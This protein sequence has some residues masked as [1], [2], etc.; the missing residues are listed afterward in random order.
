MLMG[1]SRVRPQGASWYFFHALLLCL[2]AATSAEAQTPTPTPTP[3][4]TQTPTI[5]PTPTPP[6]VPTPTQTPTP[7]QPKAAGE[8]GRES[9]REPPYFVTYDHSLEARHEFE[10]EVLSTIGVPRNN[11]SVYAAPWVELEFG[12]TSL[13]TTEVYF[14]GVT[15]TSDGSGFTGWRWENRFRPLKKEHRVNPLLYFEYEHVNEASRIQK[16]IVGSGPI[17]FAPIADLKSEWQHEIETKLILSGRVHSWNV[18][19]NF[20]L[21][22]NLTT[23][24]GIEFGY[25]AGI[26][27]LS[28]AEG[29]PNCRLCGSRVYPAFEIY[30][31]LGTSKEF[32]AK[33]ARHYI[34]PIVAWQVT[35]KST[36][37]AS[38][39]FGLTHASDHVLFRIAW[40][41][42]LF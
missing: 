25:A 35:P 20:T 21:E 18:S 13:W 30:G 9:H 24:E 27:P 33:D 10:F 19:G 40:G 29:G 1:Q 3:T 23:D 14:E 37:K 22:K 36:I 8:A 15:T 5:T 6:S 38:V 26:A 39:G 42:E 31:G 7:I 34:A 32:G 4:P 16:E 11:E 12:V 28:A 17:D 41:R 2:C